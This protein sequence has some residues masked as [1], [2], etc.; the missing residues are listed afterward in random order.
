VWQP[1]HWASASNARA[2]ENARRASVACSQLRVERAEVELYLADL[3]RSAREPA[4]TRAAPG[5]QHPA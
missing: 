4:G 2:V 3:V 1:W 5:S